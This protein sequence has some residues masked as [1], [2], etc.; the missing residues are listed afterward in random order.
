[1]HEWTCALGALEFGECGA[2]RHPTEVLATTL[3]RA[4]LLDRLGFKRIW[5][6]E[7]H[8][9]SA[10]WASPDPL[11]P[12]IATQTAAIRVGTGCV[13]ARYRQPYI[14]SSDYRTLATLFPGRVELGLG[15]GVASTEVVEALGA[16]GASF[17]RERSLERT[18]GF[19]R[20]G[21]LSA[22]S[23]EGIVPAPVGGKTPEVWVMGSSHAS[24]SVAARSGAHYC[25]ALFTPSSDADPSVVARFRD[26][27]V[28]SEQEMAVAAAA[29]WY[30]D[31]CEARAAPDAGAYGGFSRVSFSGSVQAFSE[32]LDALEDEFSGADVVLLDRTATGLTDEEHWG[33]LAELRSRG[34]TSA[35]R[36]RFE[37]PR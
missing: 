23:F 16:T 10:A 35:V 19:T 26:E 15:A 36:G 21:A 20:A 37:I 6:G 29:A 2:G 24:A 31:S 8:R 12:V 30:S 34:R 32:W 7:H 27:R 13:L 22:E 9:P 17:D 1:M 14:L 25:Y 3:A 28:S 5:I 4:R 18:M 11:V 33:A